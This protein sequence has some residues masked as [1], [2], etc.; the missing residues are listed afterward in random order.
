MPEKWAT[1]HADPET[2][3]DEKGAQRDVV[4]S[5]TYM[6]SMYA[7]PGHDLVLDKRFKIDGASVPVYDIDT[8]KG[9]D[10]IRQVNKNT[11]TTLSYET[12]KPN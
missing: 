10:Y 12:D 8:G 1:R 2:K 9:G 7:N 6:D 3:I 11:T 5:D 4:G